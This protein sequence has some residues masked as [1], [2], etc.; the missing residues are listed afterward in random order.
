MQV[1][2]IDY[3]CAPFFDAIAT[4]YPNL[5]PDVDRM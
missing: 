4:L 1:G 2:F 3:V 5:R